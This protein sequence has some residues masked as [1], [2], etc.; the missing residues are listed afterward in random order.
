MVD[1]S[2]DMAYREAVI[3]RV[4]PVLAVWALVEMTLDDLYESLSY[5]FIL[6]KTT[7]ISFFSFSYFF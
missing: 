1:F 7:P 5:L 6:S 3:L 4:M 2:W